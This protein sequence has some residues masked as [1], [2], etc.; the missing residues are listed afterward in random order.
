MELRPRGWQ[1]HIRE[2]VHSWERI[3]ERCMMCRYVEVE[4]GYEVISRE[5]GVYRDKDSGAILEQWESPEAG[6][7]ITLWL[8]P[9]ISARTFALEES[10]DERGWI[11]AKRKTEQGQEHNAEDVACRGGLL[12]EPEV[13]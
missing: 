12:S 5:M 4:G 8:D 2:Y 10:R 9:R 13:R 3:S 1:Y 11:C 6:K 7:V